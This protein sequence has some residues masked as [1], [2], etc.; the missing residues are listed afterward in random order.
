MGETDELR[1]EINELE[2]RITALEGKKTRNRKVVESEPSSVAV[3][4]EAFLRSFRNTFG[5]DYAGW[6]AKENSLAKNWLKSVPL[7]RALEYVAIYPKWKD[8][9]IIRNGHPFHLL[10][11]HYV[12][13][14]AHMRR[15]PKLVADL[16]ASMAREN[17]EVNAKVKDYESRA[18]ADIQKEQDSRDGL[19]FQNPVQIPTKT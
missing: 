13:L 18:F 5:H 8:K 14:D 6:G 1:R 9:M 4:R 10:T 15:Y 17:V 11:G 16:I 7:E 3:V 12:R 19:G 2:A